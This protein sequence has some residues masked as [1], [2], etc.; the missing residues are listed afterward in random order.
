MKKRVEQGKLF[1][2]FF[3]SYC[4][5]IVIVLLITLV[6]FTTTSATMT[7][8]ILDSCTGMLKQSA[9]ALDAFFLR[10]SNTA[11]RM[12]IDSSLSKGY[13]NLNEYN[14]FEGIRYLRRY[15]STLQNVYDIFLY[16][17]DEM[18]YSTSGYCSYR[19][20]PGQVHNFS[21]ESQ[22]IFWGEIGSNKSNVSFLSAANSVSMDYLM[23]SYPIP[24]N[25]PIPTGMVG[26][27]VGKETISDII[28]N[29]SIAACLCVETGGSYPRIALKQ[30]NTELIPY[31]DKVAVSNDRTFRADKC[32]YA[33]QEVEAPLSKMRVRMAID[34][35]W[36]LS[37]VNSLRNKILLYIGMGF[38]LLTALAYFF[39]YL[40]YSPVQKI[41]EDYRLTPTKGMSEIDVIG[42]MIRLT[43]AD[44]N[45]LNEQIA[46]SRPFIREQTRHL[47]F[48]SAD[49]DEEVIQKM[50]TLA[51]M[52]NFP[53]EEFV[54]LAFDVSEEQIFPEN[55]I[56]QE[57]VLE[58][59]RRIFI[60]VFPAFDNKYRY[61]EEL[62]VYLNNEFSAKRIGIGGVYDDI[63]RVQQSKNEAI[64]ALNTCASGEVCE[65]HELMHI[66]KDVHLG[67]YYSPLLIAAISSANVERVNAVLTNAFLEIDE[68]NET[69]PECQSA[70]YSLVQ[71]ILE[72]LAQFDVPKEVQK[73]LV[74]LNVKGEEFEY[75]LR[76]L[77]M[78]VCKMQEEAGGENT[79]V[80]NVLQ[81]L[82][83]NFCDSNLSLDMV[84][85][86]LG[87]SKSH[88]SRL[89]KE[90]IRTNYKDYVAALRIQRARRLI[91]EK[92]CKVQEVINMVGYHDINS[93]NRKYRKMVGMSPTDDRSGADF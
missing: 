31:M 24:I 66:K 16:Y 84:A 28:A 21:A 29:L 62:C 86:E 22:E 93:F 34:L 69:L 59:G 10:L 1:K 61:A 74:N 64:V 92:R 41:I 27:L 4:L 2:R 89:F 83:T 54:V 49:Q 90:K 91:K 57:L 43:L 52:D 79:F 45:A 46:D 39:S 37:S 77:L 12:A 26:F 19:V 63:R 53:A 38:V 70:V 11:S 73:R 82:E 72:V 47:L 85:I 50:L 6:I 68:M 55:K 8:Y 7:S 58:D 25:E 17:N 88:L 32:L 78:N 87:L 23:Y 18:L 42:Q 80:E 65:F 75:E 44:R 3:A 51:G 30:G 40:N 60:S 81:Y 36:L 76:A 56:G 71:I 35:D 15:R 13:M 14:A 67:L 5:I 20:Y 9:E 33:Y 48:E